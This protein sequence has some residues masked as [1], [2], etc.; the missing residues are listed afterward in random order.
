MDHLRV[1]VL[2]Q[3]QGAPRPVW[4]LW[5]SGAG[6]LLNKVGSPPPHQESPHQKRAR[7]FI[8][9]SWL[10]PSDM[11]VEIAAPFM[12][13]ICGQRSKE[14]SIW[15]ASVWPGANE[16]RERER[17]RVREV[18]RSSERERERESERA[19]ESEGEGGC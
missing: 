11:R 1:E 13:R 10:V 16:E 19:R 7:S 2:H 14:R 12:S 6:R 15:T 5:D 3:S 17:V 18:E 9:E 4:E 8:F